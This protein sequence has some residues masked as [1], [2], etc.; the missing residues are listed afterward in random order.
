MPTEDENDSEANSSIL[1]RELGK[2]KEFVRELFRPS[3]LPRKLG[4]S[5]SWLILLGI[6][7]VSGTWAYNDWAGPGYKI[8]VTDKFTIA[9]LAIAFFA[10]LFALLA[11]QVSTGPPNLELGI[12]LHGQGHPYNHRFEYATDRARW[13][14]LECWFKSPTPASEDPEEYLGDSQWSTHIA[15]MW[16][17]NKSRYPAKSPSVRVRFGD[18]TDK[19]PMGLCCMNPLAENP[20]EP[21]RHKEVG[22]GWIDTSFMTSGIVLTATQW[23]GGSTYP[24]HG[25]SSRRLPN[26]SLV[27]LY[28]S[29]IVT[30]KLQVEL[31]AEGY[32][33]VVKVEITFKVD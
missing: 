13:R 15:Y 14:R 12:M 21:W 23:D 11:Y 26:L 30:N 20:D 28:S 31:L 9:T 24:I 5:V 6:G 22:P 17:D 29:E 7:S 3:G 8:T 1:L 4:L 18:E 33:K 25:K 10:A 19:S 2:L 32:R 16:V 27:T